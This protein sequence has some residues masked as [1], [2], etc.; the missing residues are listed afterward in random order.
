MEKETAS[1]R[2]M[3]WNATP[4][5]WPPTRQAAPKQAKALSSAAEDYSANNNRKWKSYLEESQNSPIKGEA[6]AAPFPEISLCEESLSPPKHCAMNDPR[7]LHLLI[8]LQCGVPTGACKVVI[9]TPPMTHWTQQI[10][11]QKEMTKNYFLTCWS[12][13]D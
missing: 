5:E 2:C 8:P 9:I 12:F 11:T 13:M 10:Q 7:S 6:A 4:L 3:G 1:N